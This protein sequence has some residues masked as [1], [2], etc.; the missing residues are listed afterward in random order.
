[1]KRTKRPLKK[2]ILACTIIFT[3]LLCGVLSSVEYSSAKNAL[4]SQFE[5]YMGNILNYIAAEID[6]DD[7]AACIRTGVKSEKYHELQTLLD[8]ALARLDLH[9]IYIIVPLNA[10]PVDNVQNVIEGL[11]P[12]EY[13]FEPEMLDTLNTLSG[14]VY[15]PESAQK[16]LNAYQSGKLTFFEES[17]RWGD[18]YTGLLPLFDSNGKPV[19]A[20]CVDV[21]IAT[22]HSLLRNNT[23]EVFLLIVM[24]GGLFILV[25]NFWITRN[26][27]EPIELLVNSAVD[28][29]SKCRN[30][31]SPDALE[32]DV[33][34]IN[35]Q[36]EIQTLA[37]AISEMS[38]AI[39]EYAKNIVRTENELERIIVQANKDTLTE[40]R[41]KKAYEAYIAR[42]QTKMD[43][44]EKTPFA[45]LIVRL[46]ELNKI[47]ESCGQEKSG[48]Y[49]KR[50]CRIICEV[51]SH[52]AVFRISEDAFAVILTGDDYSQRE[53][54]LK[55]VRGVFR[56]MEQDESA[57]L[58][59]RCSVLFGVADYLPEQ[60]H[61]F[62]EIAN[63][64]FQNLTNPAENKEAEGGN[65]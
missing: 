55:W 50:C 6:T 31:K 54:L 60:D 15:T 30:Q 61:L 47:I 7:L 18:D 43:E 3:L 27:S 64:A 26:V 56:E 33:S 40:V 20:L 12:Y 53:S 58:W 57:P 11:T 2:S 32:F 38:E 22:I 65:Q 23:I 34:E 14:D 13:E 16:Y 19:A 52:S 1:M 59:E 5:S 21:D 36:N 8:K 62:D 9:Y 24:L 45:L 35:T 39:R 44:K 10:E 29:A 41:N 28:F 48:I 49:I 46:H 37:G 25:F 42:F 4:Y 63:R 51:F 17:S